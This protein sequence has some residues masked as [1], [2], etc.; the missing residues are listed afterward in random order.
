MSIVTASRKSCI[1]LVRQEEDGWTSREVKLVDRGT[2]TE[3][4]GVH[5]LIPIPAFSMYLIGRSHGVDLVDLDSSS[6]ICTLKT[7]SMQQRSLRVVAHARAQAAD[8]ASLT[9]AYI[10]ADTGDL[11]I[12][13][14]L[15][16]DDVDAI[17]SYN[18]LDAKNG[19]RHSWVGAREVTR[20]VVN[21]GKWEALSSGSIVGVRQRLPVAEKVDKQLPTI[22]PRISSLLRF[23]S[24][25]QDTELSERSDKTWEAWVLSH[26]ETTGDIETRPLNDLPPRS[27]SRT[28]VH[29][30]GSLMISELGPMVKL[31][32][33]SVAVGFGN[34]I[35]VVSVGHQYF[36]K[37]HDHLGSNGDLRSMM[38]RRRKTVGLTRL[39][40][41]Y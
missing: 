37:V 35:K 11:V 29:S 33:M 36:D 7:E 4:R 14:Y 12:R 9:L 20:R 24:G 19:H 32:T 18:P 39:K 38:V 34:A 23:G 2:E 13:T 30:L 21:P 28:R 16:D 1:H 31:S 17:Y 27:A 8:L 22:V 10:E 6:I 26:L 5:C 15:P 25:R 41:S 40:A 3:S